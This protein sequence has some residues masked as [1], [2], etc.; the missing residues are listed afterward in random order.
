[1]NWYIGFAAFGSWAAVA[2]FAESW[3]VPFLSFIQNQG[4]E[5]SAQ[6]LMWVWVSMAVA[7]PLAGWVSDYLQARILPTMCLLGLGLVASLV[8]VIGC[9]SQPWVVSLLLF[10]LG[11]SSAAQPITFGLI[12]DLNHKE[13]MA[14]AIALNNMILVCSTGLLT[15]VSG[16]L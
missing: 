13:N 7:S 14:T 11:V 12:N 5:Q 6:Q 3:G 9:P 15:P 4:A 2:I 8:L 1:M 16:Y 10:A